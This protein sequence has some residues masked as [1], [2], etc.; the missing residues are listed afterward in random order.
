MADYM[1]VSLWNPESIASKV[2]QY[3]LKRSFKRLFCIAIYLSLTTSS[4]R[5][6]AMVSSHYGIQNTLQ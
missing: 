4:R 3:V 5:P 2:T 1:R 6:V